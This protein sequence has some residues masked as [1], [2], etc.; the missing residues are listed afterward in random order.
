MPSASERHPIV[1]AVPKNA[2]EPQPGQAVFSRAQYSSL[3]IFPTLYMPLASSVDVKSAFLP[4]NSIPPSIGPPTTTI[5]GISSLAAAI[6]TPGTILSH[7]ASKTTASSLC[8]C[9]IISIELQI[10]SL[11]GSM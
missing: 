2:H 4:S 1:L 9:A 10:I 6:S 3:V 5:A 11:E 7:E 8:A